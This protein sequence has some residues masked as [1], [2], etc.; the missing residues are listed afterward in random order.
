AFARLGYAR[1]GLRL[2]A[3]NVSPHGR[4]LGSSAAAIT[5]AIT[6]ANA[7]VPPAARQ[8]S[9]WILQLA[10]ELEG[11]PDNVAPAIFGAAAISWQD[12]NAYRSAKVVPDAR[13]IP[14]VA[15]PAFALSTEAARAMLP[16][17]VTHQDAAA[18]AGRAALLIHA[19]RDDPSLLL[20]GTQDFLH[21]Q[22][23]AGAMAPSTALMRT[24]RAAGLAAFISGAGPTVMTLAAG[25]DE[26]ARAVDL[27]GAQTDPELAGTESGALWRVLRLAIDT[28]GAKVEVH[29]R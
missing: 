1:C 22:Y 17:S 13:V 15:V 19:L 18:N 27:I 14:V 26:A 4:G 5:A 6:A 11:H 8:D 9:G 20:A 24:L 10:S 28:E 25:P 29:R 3:Q 7:L 21:Q 12:G 2:T 23:R 16:A